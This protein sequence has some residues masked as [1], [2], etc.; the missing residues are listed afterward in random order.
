MARWVFVNNAARISYPAAG[1]KQLC[2]GFTAIYLQIFAAFRIVRI[3]HQ[4][5]PFVQPILEVTGYGIIEPNSIGW[6][7]FC[8]Q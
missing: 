7:Y 4:I 8:R 3:R 6:R 2:N 1:K 5:S